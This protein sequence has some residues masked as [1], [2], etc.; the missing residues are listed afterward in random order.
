VDRIIGVVKAYTTAVG[1][2]PF[3]TE[4]TGPEG[5]ALRERGNEYG[6]TTGRPRRCG[7]FDV[8]AVAWATRLAGFTELALTKID[9]LDE[10]SVIPECV[11]Y[12]DD[13]AEISAFP[14]TVQMQRVRPVYRKMRGWSEKTTE[15]RKMDELPGA[16]RV[17]IDNIEHLV[18]APITTVSVGP[19]RNAIVIRKGD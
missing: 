3:P 11:A 19:E 5:D 1:T 8:V 9:V 6:A 17:Y 4:L 10:T 18:G 16:T 14:T 15:A 12:Q 7:W 13:E 2:G